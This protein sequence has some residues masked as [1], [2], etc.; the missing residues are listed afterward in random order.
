MPDFQSRT[1]HQKILTS[2]GRAQMCKRYGLADQAALDAAWIEN[3]AQS[4][5]D[6]SAHRSHWVTLDG[7]EWREYTDAELTGDVWANVLAQEQALLASHQAGNHTDG[8]EVA[9]YEQLRS[10]Y[11]EADPLSDRRS[12]L[13]PFHT[14][15]DA[16]QTKYQSA[17]T[18]MKAATNKAELAAAWAHVAV[19]DDAPA[20]TALE[21]QSRSG[22]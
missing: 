8:L 21:A 6:T 3:P 14:W 22:I 19:I 16:T 1:D 2:I 15:D 17:L 7:D 9:E 4:S 10:L 13:T 11:N 20:V 18:A 5:K 12:Y